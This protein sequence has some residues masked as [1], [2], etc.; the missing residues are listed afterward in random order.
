MK[1][2]ECECTRPKN[3]KNYMSL[4]KFVWIVHNKRARSS[5]PAPT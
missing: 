5:T 2:K 1:D 3:L 4:F